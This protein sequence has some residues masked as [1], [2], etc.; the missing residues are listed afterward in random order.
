M[1]AASQLAS[2]T[3]RADR[4]EAELRRAGNLRFALGTPGGRVHAPAG[5]HRTLDLIRPP[6]AEPL[7]SNLGAVFAGPL[8]AYVPCA[9]AAGAGRCNTGVGNADSDT[10]TLDPTKL[11]NINIR[12]RGVFGG[13]GSLGPGNITALYL[14]IDKTATGPLTT[15]VFN[16]WSDTIIQVF[17]IENTYSLYGD[18][19]ITLTSNGTFPTM[20]SNPGLVSPL[21]QGVTQPYDGHFGQLQARVVR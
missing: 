10:G 8:T 6:A 5:G 20:L 2:L 4:V 13:G 11:Y 14:D 9:G 21:I 16:T 1:T 17:D 15:L 7:R 19:T 12:V 3:L 18:A